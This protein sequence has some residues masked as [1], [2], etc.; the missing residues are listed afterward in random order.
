[1]DLNARSQ[2]VQ[3]LSY[4]VPGRFG[5]DD[6]VSDPRPIGVYALNFNSNTAF[7]GIFFLVV[8]IKTFAA[9]QKDREPIQ[10]QDIPGEL[11]LTACLSECNARTEKLAFFIG[12]QNA[13]PDGTVKRTLRSR[14]HHEELPLRIE[15]V[16]GTQAVVLLLGRFHFPHDF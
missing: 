11:V 8:E 7:C 3:P 15:D 4:Q 1:M 12:V 14:I 5:I 6:N 13:R 9:R 10:T 16:K 2:A